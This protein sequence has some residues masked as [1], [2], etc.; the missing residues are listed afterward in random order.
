MMID[1]DEFLPALV[2][3]SYIP[4]CTNISRQYDGTHYYDN[5]SQHGDEYNSTPRTSLP[6]PVDST[7]TSKFNKKQ[8]KVKRII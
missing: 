1:H 6:L 4:C 5:T 8:K 2:M 7:R 3:T